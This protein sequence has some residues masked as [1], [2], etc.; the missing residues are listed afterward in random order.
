MDEPIAP[1]PGR[2]VGQS[3]PRFEDLRFITGRGRYTDDIAVAG[4]AHA[5]FARSD[6]AHAIIEAID[7]SAAATAAGVIAVLTG[8]DY[9]ADGHAPMKHTPIPTDAI[10]PAFPGFSRETTFDKGHAPLV[11]DRVR[12]VGEAVAMVV[13]E[14]LEQAIAAAELVEVRYRPLGVVVDTDD[15]I[16]PAAPA[17][18]DDCPG[19]VCLCEDFGDP[20]AT[21]RAFE[22]AH[23]VVEGTFQDSRVVTCQMEPRAASYA[24]IAARGSI[25]Q[26]T[27]RLS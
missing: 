11:I 23:L 21:A 16:A 1:R 2:L 17:L 9:L 14:T 27:T 6:Q 24:P 3:I 25:W 18:Y 15:A 13:A 5:A 7:V 26:V 10:D 22:D 20:D 4:A 12:Q 19:N 8:A